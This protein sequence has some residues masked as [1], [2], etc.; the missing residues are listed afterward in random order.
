MVKSSVGIAIKEALLLLGESQRWLAERVGVSDNAVSK[1]V[2]SGKLDKKHI[3][4]VSEVLHLS[5]E[6]LIGASPSA[7]RTSPTARDLPVLRAVKATE[8][9]ID[10]RMLAAHVDMLR[11]SA[12][13]IADQFGTSADNVLLSAMSDSRK[14]AVKSGEEWGDAWR[15]TMTPGTERA[16][17]RPTMEGSH[18]EFQA[19][20]DPSAGKD[21]QERRKEE[22]RNIDRRS[23]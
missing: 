4:L 22:R 2:K 18:E 8:G 14:G 16:L 20:S 10:A 21:A 11:K 15:W 13:Y 1:W 5:V 19:E 17:P 12:Q 23:L 6:V 3:P 9:N 7:G